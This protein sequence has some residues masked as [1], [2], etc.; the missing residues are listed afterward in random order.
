MKGASGKGF[1]LLALFLILGAVLGGI[2]GELIA[3][4]PLGGITP[5]LVKTFPIFDLP[6]ITINL[7]IVKFV[8]GMAL[9]PNLISI[10]GVVGAYFLFRRF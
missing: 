8:F 5:Y 7:Y 6:P 2:L 3:G 1:G 4:W 10:L 9:H